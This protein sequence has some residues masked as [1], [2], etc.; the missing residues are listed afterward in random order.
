MTKGCSVNNNNIPA[1]DVILFKDGLLGVEH[2]KKYLLVSSR[3]N[4]PFKYLQSIDDD[5]LAFIVIDPYLY[6]PNY[7]F[8]IFDD[9]LDELEVIEASD[10]LVLSIAV[11]PSDL[12][13][14]TANFASPVLINVNNRKGMQIILQDA[15]YKI[16]QPIFDIYKTITSQG[17][18]KCL[19]WHVNLVRQ[20]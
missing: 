7:S 17:A 14:M 10:I 19:S 8:E 20:Y 4:L 11:I 15:K 6:I 2:L 5:A 16:R 13:K 1:E 12:T 3:E 9:V 18:M